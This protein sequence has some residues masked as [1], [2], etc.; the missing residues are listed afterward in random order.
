[1]RVNFIK[2]IFQNVILN[3]LPPLVRRNASAS[4]IHG[5]SCVVGHTSFTPDLRL[6]LVFAAWRRNNAPPQ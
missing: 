1:M 3:G 6:D 2:L 4:I 5:S